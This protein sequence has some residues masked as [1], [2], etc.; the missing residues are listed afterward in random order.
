MDIGFIPSRKSPSVVWVEITEG[1]DQIPGALPP[2]GF[3]DYSAAN[4]HC[5]TILDRQIEMR[6]CVTVEADISGV[7]YHFGITK[8]KGYW[9]LS[10]GPN[11]YLA[12]CLSNLRRIDSAIMTYYADIGEWPDS[13]I[14]TNS[15]LRSIYEV[16]LLD[17]C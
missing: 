7:T 17:R 3:Q 8:A 9:E 2:N 16:I 14:M 6:G 11:A 12:A 15:N 13:S 1:S 4:C 10:G 5:L